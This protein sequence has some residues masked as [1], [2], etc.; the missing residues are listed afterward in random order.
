MSIFANLFAE[1]WRDYE[2]DGV[3]ASGVH[4]VKKSEVR[5]WGAS[6][7]AALDEAARG[8]V[9]SSRGV[10][11]GSTLTV[12]AAT[13]S[14]KIIELDTASGSVVTLP[15]ASGSMAIIR[16][17]VTVKPTSNAHI[18][19]VASSSDFLAGSVNIL[20]NDATALSA[21]AADGSSDDTI[22]MN[23]TTKG[24]LVGDWVEFV[25]VKTNIWAVRGSLVVPAGSNPADVFSATV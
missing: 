12:V 24:G 20:D 23:G 19:K 11:A 3:S 10:A 13:H 25:D 17:V 4:E 5:Q 18:V 14:D 16:C 6:A 7:E 1:I 2:T 9:L 15:A 21:Y 22:T 8:S